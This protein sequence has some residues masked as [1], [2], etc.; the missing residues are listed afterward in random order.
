MIALARERK[1]SVNLF[2]NGLAPGM[3]DSLERVLQEQ[4]RSLCLSM[5]LI[6]KRGYAH[7]RGADKFDEA[8]NQ[9]MLMAPMFTRRDV[10]TKLVL[11]SIYTGESREEL[12]SYLHRFLSLDG[13]QSV[14]ITH[15]FPWPGRTDADVLGS[16]LARNRDAVCP[17]VWNAMN[18]YWDG[19]VVP[20]SFDYD[21]QYPVGNVNDAPL[22]EIANSPQVRRFRRMHI[23]GRSQNIPLCRDCL[24]P[25]FV[26][27]V[28]VVQKKSYAKMNEE[29]KEQMLRNIMD[30]RF[31]PAK[32][33]SPSEQTVGQE[34]GLA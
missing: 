32:D 6:S 33:F 24:L 29:Q 14:Q 19:T 17:Q 27:N 11:R 22:D 34:A 23:F 25:R 7:L 8:Q 18:V 30:L 3:R 2:S 12:Q 21:A 9:L 31:D 26:T 20:C 16:R 28:I 1:I 10:K 4:P 15:A 13:L 5:D